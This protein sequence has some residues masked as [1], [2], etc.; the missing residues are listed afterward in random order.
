MADFVA[1]GGDSEREAGVRVFCSA[2]DHPLP[3]ERPRLPGVLRS[4][5]TQGIEPLLA[6]GERPALQ[7]GEGSAQ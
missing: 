3:G 5:T 4:L 7:G 6:A 1:E 2:S